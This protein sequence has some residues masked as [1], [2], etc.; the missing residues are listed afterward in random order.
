MEDNNNTINTGEAGTQT[1]D[2]TPTFTQDDVNKI[3]G[4]RLNRER[5]K[6]TADY[7]GREAELLRREYQY[8][9]REALTKRGYVGEDGSLEI[10]SV[11]NAKTVDELERA[12][13]IIEKC[14]GFARGSMEELIKR[15]RTE[16]LNNVLRQKPPETHYP[17]GIGVREA[18]GLKKE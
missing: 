16:T 4:D 11:I 3:V 7:E 2:T 18:M 8:A 15:V 1:A 5:A 12:L 17:T 6:I 10:L 13:D 9:A 14:T